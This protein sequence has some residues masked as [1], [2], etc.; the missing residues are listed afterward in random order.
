MPYTAKQGFQYSVIEFNGKEQYRFKTY[1]EAMRI[2][3]MLNEAF[4]KGY[5]F[6][7]DSFV[8][9]KEITDGF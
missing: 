7:Y 4:E 6:A 1:S 2:A 9:S 3:R 5:S 8:I